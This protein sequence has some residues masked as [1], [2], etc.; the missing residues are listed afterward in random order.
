MSERRDA[1]VAA[2][3]L[4]LAVNRLASSLPGNQVGTVGI[5][6]AYPGA[7][8][9]IPGR[10]EMTAQF[11]DMKAAVLEQLSKALFAE[12]ERVQRGA[13]GRDF[14]PRLPYPDGTPC[15]PK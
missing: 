14:L 13:Q 5:I 15:H 2:S 11:R 7:S 4:V 9:V 12:I 1:L 6:R 8:N 3:E 10:V